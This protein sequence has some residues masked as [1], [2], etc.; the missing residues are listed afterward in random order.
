[1]LADYAITPCFF[2]SGYKG[3]AFAKM[4][5]Y[6]RYAM[7]RCRHT[8]HTFTIIDEYADDEQR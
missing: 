8:R 4:L 6:A 5:R 2:F 1:M 3:A 7:R